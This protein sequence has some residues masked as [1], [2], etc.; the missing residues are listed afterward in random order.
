MTMA[1]MFANQAAATTLLRSLWSA[2]W[3]TRPYSAAALRRSHQVAAAILNRG[4]APVHRKAV[5]NA[6]RLGKTQLR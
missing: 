4:L 1:A 2:P 5:A 6:K 3:S